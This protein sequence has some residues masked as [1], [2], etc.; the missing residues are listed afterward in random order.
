MAQILELRPPTPR[1]PPRPAPRS[2]RCSRT[3]PSRSCRAPPR[4]SPT[5]APSCPPAPASI[6]PTSTAPTSPRCSA[7]ARRLAD[8]GFAVMPHFP[9]RGIAAAAEL[10]A[11]IAAY[12]DVG[13]RAGA[14]DRRRHRHAR[15]APSPRRCSCCGPAVFDA[16]GF[17][18][19]HVAGHPEGNRRHRPRRRRRR[20]DGGARPQGRL[21][22]ARP[23]RAMAI[24]TQFCFD[25]APVD[26]LGRP[27]A[28]PRASPCRSTSASPAPPSS[29]P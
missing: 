29:R 27:P 11:R 24:A 26:R 18:D 12:A 23:T 22:R 1:P 17:T 10:D 14:G 4:R 28:A 5:S 13:V 8:E 16:R 15:A 20:R 2:T 7:A 9:A 21:R 19:L 25:A 6:S 3:S